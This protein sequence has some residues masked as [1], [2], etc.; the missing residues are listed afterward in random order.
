MRHRTSRTCSPAPRDLCLSTLTVCASTQPIDI[1]VVQRARATGPK[2]RVSCATFK[3][4][5]P[6]HFPFWIIER[7]WTCSTRWFQWCTW[8]VS[9]W[10]MNPSTGIQTIVVC[11]SRLCLT[12]VAKASY[13]VK[14]RATT[15]AS[16]WKRQRSSPTN[17]ERSALARRK[18]GL[19][20]EGSQRLCSGLRIPSL[21]AAHIDSISTK[22]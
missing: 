14:I 11:G 4:S 13:H 20:N 3:G 15:S 22:I 1:T 6:P 5:V 18:K 8:N 12:Y 17:G 21:L 2:S 19:K 16:L 9:K 10:P 7:F